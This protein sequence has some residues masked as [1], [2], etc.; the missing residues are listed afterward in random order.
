M[1]FSK[2]GEKFTQPSGISQLM[3]DIGDVLNSDKPVYMLGV[4]NPASI[5]AVNDE[6]LTTLQ[7][8]VNEQSTSI[9]DSISHYST[10]QGDDKLIETLVSFFNQRYDWQLTK[11]N[12]VLTNGS[13]NAFFYLFNLLAGEFDNGKKKSILLPLAPEYIGYADVQISGSHFVSVPPIIETMTYKGK[14]GFFKYRVDFDA[15]ETLPALQNG[16]IGAI[17]C[18]RPTNPTGN[19]LTD[20]EMARLDNLAKR[21][22]IPL[23]VDNAYGMPFPNI[24]HTSAT[25]T[26]HDN[27]VLCFSLSKVGLPS[28]RTGIVVACPPIVKAI[29]SLNAI[30][31]L[32]PTRFG[33][34]ITTPLLKNG[35]IEQLS[36]Q[37]I[38]PFY[39]QQADFAIDLIQQ[40]FSNYPVK[41]HQPEGAI[42]L[43]LWF[44][45][46]PITTMQLYQQLKAKGVIII[47]S[48]H[49]FVGLDTTNFR[50]AHECIRV[51]IAQSPEILRQGITIIAETVKQLYDNG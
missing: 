7:Q 28:V 40:N 50:H 23:I 19:V 47:P 24:I 41:I 17:C 44:E 42:F 26:W 36:N 15:L 21:Y 13:Q 46:L 25:L 43:W 12:I 48:E 8:L 35:K 39:Q 22:Q 33:A 49:F 45:H 6:F 9:M 37:V 32:A 4:G 5:Q 29:S 20:D 16:E 30:L 38:Q 3:D 31:N 51:S 34:T 1:Q 18:S 2:F 27:M 14:T 11:Q 10:P